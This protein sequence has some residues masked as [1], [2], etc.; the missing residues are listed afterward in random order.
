VVRHLRFG[1]RVVASSRVGL[2]TGLAGAP[3][4]PVWL[5]H[6]IGGTLTVFV[7]ASLI[8]VLGRRSSASPRR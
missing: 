3:P 7:V 1:G 4:A 2:S 6:A 8:A 5:A